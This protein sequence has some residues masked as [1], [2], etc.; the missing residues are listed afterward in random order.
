MFTLDPL[1]SRILAM[2]QE[3]SMSEEG[4]LAGVEASFEE[5]PETASSDLHKFLEQLCAH[6]LIAADENAAE[7]KSR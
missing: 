2:L 7:F 6:R 4:L 3:G 5:V 1:A